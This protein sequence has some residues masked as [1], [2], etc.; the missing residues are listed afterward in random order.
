MKSAIDAR[1]TRYPGYAI[2]QRLRHKGVES[3]LTEEIKIDHSV[4]ST[5]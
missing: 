2:S 3:V 4:F 1:T 5:A